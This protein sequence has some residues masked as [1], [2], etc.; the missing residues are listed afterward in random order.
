VSN[1]DKLA[2]FTAWCE[3]NITGDEKGQAQIFLDRLFQAFGQSGCLDAGGTTEFRVR[4]SHEDGGGTAFADYI[5]KPVVLIEMKKRGENL[6]K[7]YRPALRRALQ[8]RR[9]PRL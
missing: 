6:Q 3:K 1:T 5:W 7:H 9:V 8:F 2:E 4:K